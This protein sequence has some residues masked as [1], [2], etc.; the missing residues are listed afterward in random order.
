[1]THVTDLPNLLGSSRVK[2]AASVIP[3]LMWINVGTLVLGSLADGSSRQG[4]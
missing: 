4:G 1:M 3:L 2:A